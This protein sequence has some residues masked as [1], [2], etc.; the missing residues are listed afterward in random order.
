M[1]NLVTV[2]IMV[3]SS[4]LSFGQNTIDKDVIFESTK[5]KDLLYTNAKMFIAENFKSANDVIQLDDKENGVILVKGVV[6]E[7]IVVSVQSL[8]YYFSFTMK[9]MIK[10]NKYRMVIDNIE[11]TTAPYNYNTVLIN[12][13]R[14]TMT[15]GIFKS[16]YEELMLKL[17]TSIDNIVKAFESSMNKDGIN[18]DW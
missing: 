1:K 7:N 13:F 14:G 11:N 10:D 12:N 3:I 16:K 6:S 18:T 9:I 4:L 5:N 15:E 2:I 17:S 8:T